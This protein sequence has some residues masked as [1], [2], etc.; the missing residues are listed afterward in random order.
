L[1]FPELIFFLLTL[2]LRPGFRQM[3]VYIT[4]APFQRPV[5]GVLLRWFRAAE[6]LAVPRPDVALRLPPLG[7]VLLRRWPLQRH[8]HNPL[9]D[10]LDL[11]FGFVQ[12]G[13][14]VLV[15]SGKKMHGAVRSGKNIG[16]E[17]Y[18]YSSLRLLTATEEKVWMCGI[19]GQ[20][21]GF[22]RYPFCPTLLVMAILLSDCGWLAGQPARRPPF[23]LVSLNNPLTGPVTDILCLVATI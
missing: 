6:V 1:I 19:F 11:L 8:K 13:G 16:Y 20:F 15:L 17:Y 7:V 3:P 9:L 22:D 10:P 23:V 18:Y 5:G 21:T 2:L 4:R 14:G 12:Q